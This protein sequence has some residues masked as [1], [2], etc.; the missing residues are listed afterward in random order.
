MRVLR[1]VLRTIG[2]LWSAFMILLMVL[3]LAL[4]VAMTM[5]PAVFSAVS[6][7]VGAVA[8]VAGIRTPTVAQRFDAEKIKLTAER[9]ALKGQLASPKVTHR[10]AKKPMREAVSETS[11]RIAKRVK[12]AATRNVAATFGEAIPFVGVGV[13]VAATVWELKDTCDLLK[14]MR[15]LDAAFNPDNPI[16]PADVCGMEV[17]TKEKIVERIASAPGDVW[18]EMI[19]QHDGLP[20]WQTVKKNGLQWLVSVPSDAWDGAGSVLDEGGRFLK[21]EFGDLKNGAT[22]WW[23]RTP[24]Q[25][26]RGQETRR[27]QAP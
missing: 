16:D 2:G 24:E 4:S 10:G 17:P 20:D 21:Q 3:C 19:R 13:I 7:V 1:F 27:E 26:L 25:P 8:D 6:G 22:S 23:E 12:F 5:L 11:A 9:D 15:E 18:Q 14:D